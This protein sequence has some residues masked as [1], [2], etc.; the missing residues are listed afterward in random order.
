M[1]EQYSEV[2][3]QKMT[4]MKSIGVKPY[5]GKSQPPE[6]MK[7]LDEM[8]DPNLMYHYCKDFG[9]E[10]DNCRKLQQKI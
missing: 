2:S 6:N 4:G 8:T 5:F 7:G 3:Q 1:H 10:L 9:H